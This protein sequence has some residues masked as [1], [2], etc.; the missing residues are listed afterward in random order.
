MRQMQINLPRQFQQKDLKL[1]N[2]SNNSNNKLLRLTLLSLL[3]PFILMAEWREWT[4]IK[5][6]PCRRKAGQGDR[7]VNGYEPGRKGLKWESLEHHVPLQAAS[8]GYRKLT[9]HYITTTAKK[10]KTFHDNARQ[11]VWMN[12][13]AKIFTPIWVNTGWEK[14]NMIQVICIKPFI[15]NR[16]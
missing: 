13:C 6:T 16:K 10:K 9:Q 8:W 15:I 3:S 2:L 12:Y 5:T 1:N 7:R 4:A 14:R 11:E